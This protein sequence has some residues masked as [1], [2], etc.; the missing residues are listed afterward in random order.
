MSDTCAPIERLMQTLRVHVPGATDDLL[1]LEVFNAIDEFFRRTSAWRYESEIQLSTETQ[2]Y[3]LS[4]PVDSELVRM[5]GVTLN[6][7]PVP[8]AGAQ[9]TIQSAFGVITPELTFADGDAQYDPD[10]TDL[11]GGMF[12]YAIYNPSY[13]SVT[14][15]P[16]EEQTK[17]PLKAVMALT[18]AKGCLEAECESWQL[19]DWTYAMFF[20]EWLDGTLGRLYQMPAKPWSEPTKAVY[21][22]KRFRNGMAFRKQEAPKGFVYGSP[23]WHFPRMSGWI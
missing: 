7:V 6:G 3:D 5:L 22:H 23:G 4:L 14:S 21:H 11:A 8:P 9:G 19:P 10:A 13:I 20:Q 16:D 18:I 1:K 15:L 17:Q 12:T 2:E